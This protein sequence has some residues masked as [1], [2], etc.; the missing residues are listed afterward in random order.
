MA[1]PGLTANLL[2]F[3]LSS[4]LIIDCLIAL[5]EYSIINTLL[6]ANYAWGYI[7]LIVGFVSLLGFLGE[8]FIFAYSLGYLMMKTYSKQFMYRAFFVGLLS[9]SIPFLV[10]TVPDI[11]IGIATVLS[12]HEYYVASVYVFYVWN[13]ALVLFALFSA[14]F[15]SQYAGFNISVCMLKR[16]KSMTCVYRSMRRNLTVGN[17]AR[18]VITAILA[19]FISTITTGILS[20]LFPAL[21]SPILPAK[22]L[23]KLGGLGE[24]WY[25]IYYRIT[26]RFYKLISDPLYYALY[27]ILFTRVFGK[28][29]LESL[30]GTMY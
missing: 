5:I 8:F 29:I 4:S 26:P 25:E 3:L 12:P 1:R 23:L 6:S 28:R 9:A 15:Y 16:E 2:V 10:I 11:I 27:I 24:R 30:K 7:L 17:V 18:F 19:L 22:D 13:I 21:N 14:L 20:I